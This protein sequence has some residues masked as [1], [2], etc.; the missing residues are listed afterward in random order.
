MSKHTIAV[1]GEALVDD[2]ITEQVVGGAPFN[3]A[4]S[5]AAFGVATLMVTRI[6]ADKNGT[7]LRNEFTRFG[8]SEAALQIDEREATGRVVVERDA[9][10]HRFIIL[11]DQAYDYIEAAPALQALAEAQPKVIYFG[12]MAQRHE[13]SRATLRAMLE[14]SKAQR[15]LDLNVREGQVTERI[16]HESLKLADIVK[17]NE[18][19]LQDLFKWYTHTQ[20]ADMR[21]AC[22]TL[23]RTF[24]LQGLIVTLGERGAM[25]FAA[26]GT[27]TANHEC[28]APARIVDTVGAGD[29][30][31][32]V[33]LFGQSQGWPLPLTLARANAFAGAICG[34]SGAVPADIGFYTPWI[35]RW[36]AGAV[37]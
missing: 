21:E 1:F 33:F 34:I 7:L 27:V 17:V 28:H 32:A 26:D 4:R 12:T 23:M 25:Y 22:Q 15:Y 6:G 31:S 11:P 10:G 3:V 18:D 8:M 24:D 20:P 36:R 14:A 13:Q 29:A 5:L 30:F 37:A 19:E 16:A 9:G 2:F 35:A